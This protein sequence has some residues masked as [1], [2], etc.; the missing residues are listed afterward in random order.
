MLSFL[1]LEPDASHLKS[2][3]TLLAFEFSVSCECKEK[4][5][6]CLGFL[7]EANKSKHVT[8][9]DETSDHAEFRVL[10]DYSRS[11]SRL[12]TLMSKVAFSEL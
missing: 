9:H 2:T 4:R 12:N 6:R 8:V 1:F 11:L 10:S 7:S 5:D 3:G